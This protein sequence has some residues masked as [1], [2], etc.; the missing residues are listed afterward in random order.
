MLLGSRPARPGGIATLTLGESKKARARSQ[1]A[2]GFADRPRQSP[3]AVKAVSRSERNDGDSADSG[4]S[5]SAAPAE[6]LSV[7]PLI[8]RRRSAMSGLRRL[9]TSPHVSNAQTA[10]IHGPRGERVK[11]T[12]SIRSDL[13]RWTGGIR[14]N[15]VIAERDR[16]DQRLNATLCAT[17]HLVCYSS[18]GAWDY[19]ALAKATSVP[20]P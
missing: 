16:C 6:T 9:E 2:N 17:G 11:S 5:P 10:V 12:L 8:P 20:R 4:P 19:G 7:Q 13:L 15:A 14:R 1:I 18:S 3:W